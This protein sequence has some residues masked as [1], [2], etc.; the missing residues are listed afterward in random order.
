MNRP[1]LL[2][3]LLF[4]AVFFVYLVSPM[5]TPFDS[6]WTVHTALSLIHRHDADLNEYEPLLARDRFYAIECIQPGGARL[7]PVKQAGACAGGHLYHFYP[8]AVP[9]LVSP[10]LAALE[11]GLHLAQPVLA[12]IASKLPPGF[13]RSLLEGDLVAASMPAELILASIVVALAAVVVF[14]LARSLAGW[15][16]AL[17]I[18]L[19]FAFATPAWS[20]GSRA[21]WMHGFSMLLLPAALW[22]MLRQ[23]WAA[24]GALLALAFFCRPTNV[25][26]LAFAALWA[27][28]QGRAQALRFAAGAVPVAAVF[29]AINF[30][31]YGSPLAPF[32]FVKRAGTASLGLHPRIG[33]ALLGNLVSPSRGIFVFSPVFL[34]SLAG[35]WRWLRARETHLLGFYL[36]AVCTAHYLLMCGYE[37]WFG[38]HSYGPRYMSDLSSLLTLALIPVLPALRSWWSR[39]LFGAALAVSLF[40]HAQG[41]WCWP[42][43]DWNTTP[44]ELRYSQYRL[45]D[46]RDPSFLR[47]FRTNPAP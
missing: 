13:R 46:W 22:A 3:L 12:P 21:L 34:F 10:L 29:V 33:E 42:C 24:A 27:L 40:M 44:V 30:A 11:T 47:N 6:R 14:L 28:W 9:I 15:R 41:A 7:Y 16:A 1:W 5:A 23:R 43:V 39:A 25:V 35:I 32:F 18:A 8:A 2:P 26:P 4:A 37:D 31:C 38:G 36:A 45:W 20:T 19:V 17:F